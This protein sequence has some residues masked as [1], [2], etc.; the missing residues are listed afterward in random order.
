[1]K[2]IKEAKPGLVIKS[3]FNGEC[4]II[5]SWYGSY[6]IGVKTIHVSNPSEWLIEDKKND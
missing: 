2:D 6:S 4:Y 3:L 1:M 5:T